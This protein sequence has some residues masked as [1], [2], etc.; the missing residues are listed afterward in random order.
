LSSDWE[1]ELHLALALYRLHESGRVHRALKTL[2]LEARALLAAF[3]SPHQIV[4]EVKAMRALQLE[5]DRLEPTQPAR[6]A[7][8][9]HHAARMGL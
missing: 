7:V 6:A 1:P 9:R 2:A 4:E 3:A 5:A 8:L